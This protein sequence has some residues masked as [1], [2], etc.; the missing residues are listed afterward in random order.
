MDTS[1]NYIHNKPA[2]FKARVIKFILAIVGVKKRLEK[3]MKGKLYAQEP[4]R[5][6]KALQNKFDVAV[7]EKKGRKI[8]TFKPKHKTSDKVV[9]YLHGGAY[10]FNISMFHWKFVEELLTKTN[11]TI[12]VPDYPL[13]PQATCQDVF[14]FIQGIYIDLLQSNVSPQNINIIGDSAGGGMALGFAQQ[15]RDENKPQPAQIILLS[16]W[17]DITM[18]NAGINEAEKEDKMLGAKWLRL[19]GQMYA[20]ASDGKDFRVSPIYGNLRGLGK[21]SVFIGTH[22]LFISDCRKLKE[23]LDKANISFNYFEY[24]KMFHAW[25]L[26]TSLEESKQAI[27]QMATI[28]H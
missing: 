3:N 28:L 7:T 24:P 22:D 14:A 11:A 27:E 21:I 4:A 5:L 2:S 8:W 17:L 15:L 10:V 1:I 23:M 9:L 18:S 12:I 6:P 20:G 26:V 13:A 25:M 16:P 19:A